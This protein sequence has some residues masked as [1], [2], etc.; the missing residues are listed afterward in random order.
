MLYY[1]IY[2]WI[3]QCK[4]YNSGWKC[5]DIFMPLKKIYII[6]R[7]LWIFLYRQFWLYIFLKCRCH[8]TRYMIDYLNTN[9]AIQIRNIQIFYAIKNVNIYYYD[10]YKFFC[11]DIFGEKY[12]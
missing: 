2:V 5:T 7:C 4:Y 6:F 3:Y 8:A 12:L 11:T 10:G 1:K 9:F